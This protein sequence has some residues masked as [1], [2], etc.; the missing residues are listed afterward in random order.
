MPGYFRN[1]AI[2]IELGD[3]VFWTP[4]VYRRNVTAEPH[5]RA[6]QVMDSGGGTTGLGVQGQRLRD[7]LGDAERYVYEHLH[8]LATAAAGTVGAE[9]SW[10]R[11]VTAGQSVCIAAAGRVHAFRFADVRY[12]FAAPSAPSP[13]A[14]QAP[15]AAAGTYSGTSTLQDYAAGGVTVGTHP[16]GMEIEMVRQFP[17]RQVPRARGARAQG[18]A[19][20]AVLR[21]TVASHAVADAAH[22][23]DYLAALAR[24]I[25][26]R[27]VDLT[28]NG[29]TYEDVVLSE[30]RPDQTDK[31]HTRFTAEFLMEA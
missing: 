19:R 24:Q 28:G 21:L 12:D 25:G 15:P 9:D 23:A 2:A 5:G 18:P 11:R 4:A 8:A 31:R 3:H 20:E 7:N 6:A 1:G 30:L 29:N 14:W 17:L 16:E 13:P 10:G 26:P 22:L 27:P